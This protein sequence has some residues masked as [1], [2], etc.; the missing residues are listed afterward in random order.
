L[1]THLNTAGHQVIV[2][3]PHT[4]LKE[5]SGIPLIG[6][7]GIPLVVY[8]ELRLN[9]VNPVFLKTIRDFV[10]FLSSYFST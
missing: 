5:F 7:A 4:S 6:T 2:L 3:C 10:C 1:L 8:P 9:F